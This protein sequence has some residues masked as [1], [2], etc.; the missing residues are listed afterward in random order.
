MFDKTFAKWLST[1]IAGAALVIGLS[2]TAT[3]CSD[4]GTGGQTFDSLYYEE[5]SLPNGQR[6][7][8]IGEGNVGLS[9]DWAGS[10]D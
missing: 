1:I 7:W 10:R 9:C 5:V 6:V 4:N 2:F 8:C 3:S